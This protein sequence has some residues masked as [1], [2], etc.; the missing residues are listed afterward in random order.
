MW[1]AP[2]TEP[3]LCIWTKLTKIYFRQQGIGARDI[4][5]KRLKIKPHNTGPKAPNT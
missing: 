4:I 3:I 1:P 2:A 5:L